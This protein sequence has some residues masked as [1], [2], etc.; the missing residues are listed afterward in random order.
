MVRLGR[1]PKRTCRN[2]FISWTSCAAFY[3]APV[4][5][6]RHVRWGGRYFQQFFG[7]M[8]AEA[9]LLGAASLLKPGLAGQRLGE[10][11]Q[12]LVHPVIDTGMVV[13]EL[14]VAM[15]NAEF[16]Q[17][18]HKPAGAV[19]QIELILLA[20][21]D[22]ERLQPAEIV[23]V[24]F[25]RNDRVVTQPVRPAFLDNLAGVERDRQADPRNCVGSGS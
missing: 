25:D 9:G 3:A 18:P 21:V 7:A 1:H 16:V 23:R 17:A 13:G 6:P 11:R 2:T 10:K 15:R 12:A 14:L 22:V 5:S 4:P 8:P 24:G 20:A 19:E